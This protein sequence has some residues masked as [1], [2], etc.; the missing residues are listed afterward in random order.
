VSLT[1]FRVCV[2]GVFKVLSLTKGVRMPKYYIGYDCG[3]MGTKVAIYADDSRLLSEA[4][5]PHEIKYPKPGWAEM[6][7]DQFYRVVAEGIRECLKKSRIDPKDVRAISCSGII[8]GFLPIDEN[9][10]PVGPY[11]PYLDGR[12]KEETRYVSEKVD[13]IWADESGNAD[14]GAYMPPMY[15]K[16][17]LNNDDNFRKNARKVVTAAHYVMGKLGGMRLSTG[18]TCRVGS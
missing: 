8:C 11:I 17:L 2:F 15:C 13:Q 16:W 18:P 5:R 9:W 1:Y 12:A 6:E 10:R 4:Y 3:T 7:P 14:I